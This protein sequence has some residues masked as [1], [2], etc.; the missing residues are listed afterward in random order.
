MARSRKRLKFF[1]KVARPRIDTT[2]VEVEATDDE[3]AERKAL[4]KAKRLPQ[5]SLTTQP[6]DP[7]AYRPHVETMIAEDE[8][9]GT[10]QSDR[11]QVADL[12]AE[13]ETRYLLLK[14]NCDGA[15]G[16]LMLQPWL[17]VD[18]PDLLTSDLCRDWLGSLN[19]LGLTHM[20]ERLDDLAGGSPFMPSDRILF[21]PPRSKKRDD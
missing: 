17:V 19:E 3:D 16:D 15:E 10:E 6:F 21:A 11:E 12:L 2:I 7:K 14:A 1:V 20:S 13:T 8:F 5:S 18:Q 9:A 4:Q